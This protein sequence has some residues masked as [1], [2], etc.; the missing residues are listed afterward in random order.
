MS[1]VIYQIRLLYWRL[2]LCYSALV[3]IPREGLYELLD[4]HKQVEE[5]YKENIRYRKR[6]KD[7]SE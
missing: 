4:D 7:A 1:E 6:K 3:R 5:F 2:W